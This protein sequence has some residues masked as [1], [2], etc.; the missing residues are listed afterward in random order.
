MSN[1]TMIHNIF[2]FLHRQSKSFQ[3]FLVQFRHQF[4]IPGHKSLNFLHCPGHKTQQLCPIL[5]HNDFILDPDWSIVFFVSTNHNSPDPTKAAKFIDPFWDKVLGQGFIFQSSVYG[6]V[7][8]INS[9]LYGE[10]LQHN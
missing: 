1:F 7:N 5:R 9:R 4:I 6:K 10:H 3:V 2:S 8:K